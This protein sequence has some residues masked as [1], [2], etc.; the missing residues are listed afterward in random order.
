M[1]IKELLA[2][3]ATLCCKLDNSVKPS[4]TLPQLD[5]LTKKLYAQKDKIFR[6]IPWFFLDEMDNSDLSPFEFWES[7][8]NKIKKNTPPFIGWK[9]LIADIEQ[10]II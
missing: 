7:T 4:L 9:E 1:K 10:A 5:D 6:H 8:F 3:N 2:E